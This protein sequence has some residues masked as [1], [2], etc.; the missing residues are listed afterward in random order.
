MK[1]IAVSLVLMLAAALL[2]G[3]W[4]A[5]NIEDMD[6][7]T[8]VVVD[9]KDDVYTFYVETI[10]ISSVK[11][12]ETG[13]EAGQS[14]TVVRGAGESFAQARMCLDKALNKPIYLGAVQSLIMTEAMADHGI[15]EY[16][17]RVRELS[18]YRKTMDMII[19]PDLPMNVLSIKPENSVTV[20]FAIEDT[21]QNLL[22]QG[23][24]FHMSLS[25]VLQKLSAKNKCYLLSTL[26][27][28]EEQIV[29]LGYTVF[30]GGR[31]EGFIPYEQA[32]GIV[33]M[34]LGGEKTKPTF[35]Y[36][37]KQEQADYT[38][39]TSLT[40]SK[41]TVEWDG[42]K[43]FFTIDLKF[44]SKLLYQSV[45]VPY[46]SGVERQIKTKLSYLLKEEVNQAIRTSLDYG[47]DYL[48]FSEPFRVKYPG[49]YEQA[50]WAEI[51]ADAAFT[52]NVDVAFKDN[53][54]YDYSGG[55]G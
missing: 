19:T 18:D 15:E 36:V 33:Y 11:K 23:A 42:N 49:V 9:Y 35:L 37:V 41:V 54:A 2:G 6:I 34:V 43:A 32:R 26:G 29:L 45:N 50:D 25:D 31:R 55:K 14:T 16:T 53:E 8:A 7:C 30:D 17:Y 1:K 10:N 38:L 39:K 21:L 48:Y 27:I 13:S 51:F 44:S 12:V 40:G 46:S 28:K 5:R 4:D 24:T 20:G 22:D 3:C 52:V 47:C